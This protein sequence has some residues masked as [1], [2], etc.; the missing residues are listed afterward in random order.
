MDIV[1]AVI[2]LVYLL[3]VLSSIKIVPQ[4][5]E[6]VI[7][8]VGKYH[9][10][11]RAGLNFIIPIVE[12]VRQKVNIREQFINIPSQSVITKD[13]A[14]VEI[15]AIVFYRVV[16]SFKST[17][18]ITNIEASIVQLALT[19]LRAIIGTME[20]EH[21]LSNREE[22]N[23]KLKENLSG[24]ES[25]WGII[26]TRV[27][28]KDII[29][30]E[31]IRKAMEKQIQADRE[32]RAIVLQAEAV[33]EK[34]RLESE[35]YLIAQTNKAEAVKRVGEAQSEVIRM[36][37]NAIKDT[38]DLAGFLQLGERYV[39]AIKDISSSQNSKIVFLPGDIIKALKEM[40]NK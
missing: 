23:A 9:K 33:K 11:L 12:S 31:T 27:E 8:R 37:G 22:I 40:F 36:L 2:V 4:G 20:L 14:S 6:W 34:Q 18:N 30:P 24:I 13:N 3:L 16:D 17:Y 7:E 38:S 21:A 5:E 1:L 39:E 26:L 32:K 25:E 28:I 19:N 29:P 35:G 10:T 15:D